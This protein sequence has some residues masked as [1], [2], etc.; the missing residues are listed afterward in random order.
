MM[1][2]SNTIWCVKFLHIEFH[3][4]YPIFFKMWIEHIWFANGSMLEMYSTCWM[5]DFPLRFFCFAVPLDPYWVLSCTVLCWVVLKV[6]HSSIITGCW[7]NIHW[8]VQHDM[9]NF[10]RPNSQNNFFAMQEYSDGTERLTSGN[11]FKK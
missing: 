8:N 3:I 6:K 7:K 11:V 10:I 1:Q 2:I 9:G 4:T 5:Q